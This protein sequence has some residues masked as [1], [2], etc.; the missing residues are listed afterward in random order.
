M[1][2]LITYQPPISEQEFYTEVAK[3]YKD[4]KKQLLTIVEEIADEQGFPTGFLA[5][6]STRISLRCF[7]EHEQHPPYLEKARDGRKQLL[8][9]LEDMAKDDGA[10]RSLAARTAGG[11]EVVGS[12][13]TVPTKLIDSGMGKRVIH[14]AVGVEDLEAAR[15]FYQLLFPNIEPR[16]GEL[17]LGTGQPVQAVQWKNDC[18]NFFL[19]EGHSRAKQPGL[20]HIGIQMDDMQ[21]VQAM[22]DSLKAA[23]YKLEA[24]PD[25]EADRWLEDKFTGVTIEVF[26][27]AD[28]RDGNLDSR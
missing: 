11:R 28:I 7:Q 17:C 20:D 2:A 3:R 26:Q 27:N 9:V 15:Q 22:R 14:I 10:W 4:S 13:P 25:G 5:S 18:V 24:N 16:V 19:F 23:G 6:W 1:D 12:S 21:D 8:Q